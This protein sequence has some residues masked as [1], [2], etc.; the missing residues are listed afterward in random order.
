MGKDE[1]W[2]L[3]AHGTREHV[4]T[5]R[6]V[7]FADLLAHL[8]PLALYLRKALTRPNREGTKFCRRRRQGKPTAYKGTD[9]RPRLTGLS[10]TAARQLF[11]QFQCR[12]YAI[13][14]ENLLQR[15]FQQCA[16]D[17]FAGRYYVHADTIYDLLFPLLGEA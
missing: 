1:C 17:D 2:L 10:E 5:L 15:L 12:R 16:C 13:P 9:R 6:S 11:K 4:K 7:T 8:Y 14:L 3:G